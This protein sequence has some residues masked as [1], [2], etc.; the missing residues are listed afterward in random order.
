MKVE[1]IPGIGEDIAMKKAAAALGVLG[2][3]GACSFIPADPGSE[4]VR[5]E[6]AERVQKCEQKGSTFSVV[7]A[8]F[9][10]FQRSRESIESDLFRISANVAV[11]QG[12]NVLVPVGSPEGG[13]QKFDI[14]LCK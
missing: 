5:L 14:Y 1:K 9:A 4:A 3:L 11:N 10:G 12:G 8:E 6:T 13:K 7:V 2:L